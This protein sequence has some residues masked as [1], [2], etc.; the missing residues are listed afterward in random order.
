MIQQQ[1][2]QDTSI[3]TKTLNEL[4][5]E[6]VEERKLEKIAPKTGY[7]NL[8]KIVKGFIPGHLYTLTGH[9]N[10]GKTSMAVNFSFNVARQG[11]KVLYVALEP[12]TMF[13][14]FW[15]SIK[16]DKPFEAL[17]DDDI[18]NLDDE[19]IQILGKQ[20]LTKVSD[21]VRIVKER[22]HTDL[23]IIDHIGYFISNLSNPV[24]EQSN[25][26]KE[27]ADLAKEKNAAIMMIAHVNK[28][29]GK[30]PTQN[31]VSGSGAFK[32]DST[33]L[34]ILIRDMDENDQ[35]SV[36]YRNTGLLIISKGKPGSGSVKLIFGE[37]KA[38]IY[39][40]EERYGE[41]IA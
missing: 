36:N 38:K 28:Q 31:D 37:K 11:K 26:I 15:A 17:S 29:A 14:E 8:D 41:E 40:L 2:P 9:T 18:Q 4:A 22:E 24:Q 1:Y 3:T 32:Q 21:L 33:D 13:T 39:E 20:G 30:I 34:W 6:R 12:G 19:N 7:S 16:Y 5:Q 27:L 23:I 35:Y 10:V 25:A